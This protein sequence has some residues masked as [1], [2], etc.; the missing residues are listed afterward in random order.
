[1]HLLPHLIP[2]YCEIPDIQCHPN[3]PVVESAEEPAI[4]AM[5]DHFGTDYLPERLEKQ[6]QFSVDQARNTGRPSQPLL[7][8]D[9]TDTRGDGRLLMVYPVPD[10]SN[11]VNLDVPAYKYLISRAFFPRVTSSL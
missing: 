11:L 7:S 3:E 10:S 2:S 1:M 8:R 5:P 9:N 4:P 6:L